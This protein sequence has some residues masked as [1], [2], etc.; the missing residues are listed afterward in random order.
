MKDN[1]LVSVFIAS[2]AGELAFIKSLLDAN[3]IEYAVPNEHFNQIQPFIS[4]ALPLNVMVF[5]RDAENAR[6]IIEQ[7]EKDIGVGGKS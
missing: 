5:E 3:N 6:Q 2:N 1:N 4:H 7:Y